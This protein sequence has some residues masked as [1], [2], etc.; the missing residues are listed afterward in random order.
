MPIVLGKIYP[1]Q[2]GKKLPVEILSVVFTFYYLYIVHTYMPNAHT[3][4]IKPQ[5]SPCLA[6]QVVKTARLAKN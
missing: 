5:A 2:P 4:P 1:A 6:I 3:W